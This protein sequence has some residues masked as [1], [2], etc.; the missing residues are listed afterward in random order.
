MDVHGL[1]AALEEPRRVGVPELVGR[2]L[3]VEA[4]AIE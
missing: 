4:R 3:L 2:D 1:G